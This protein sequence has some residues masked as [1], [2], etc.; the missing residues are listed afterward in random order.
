MCF[1]LPFSTAISSLFFAKSTG[2]PAFAAAATSLSMFFWS[3][4]AY[5]SAGAPCSTCVSRSADE[6]KLNVTFVPG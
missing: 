5:T 1:G 6:P 4:E 2:S 3:A